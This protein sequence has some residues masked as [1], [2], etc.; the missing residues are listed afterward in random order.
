[1]FL[2][3]YTG[4]YTGRVSP[5]EN[6]HSVLAKLAYRFINYGM[7]FPPPLLYLHA[8]LFFPFVFAEPH[9]GHP[10]VYDSFS[11]PSAIRRCGE[12]EQCAPFFFSSLPANINLSSPLVTVFSFVSAR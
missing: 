5:G 9:R 3:I 2:E 7:K 11:I 4:L 12:E 8:S 10:R 1:M 6:A